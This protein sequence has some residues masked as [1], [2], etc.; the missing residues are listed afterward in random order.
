[1]T[2]VFTADV[3]IDGGN[4]KQRENGGEHHSAN[5]GNS[6]RDPAFRTST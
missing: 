4:Y 5:D 2:D 1:M 3:G 6:H